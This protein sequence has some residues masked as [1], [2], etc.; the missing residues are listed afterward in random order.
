MKILL[1]TGIYPPEIGGPATFVP[2]LAEAAVAAGHEVRVLTYGD[3]GT[4]QGPTWPVTVVPRSGAAVLRYLRYALACFGLARS[5]D[6]VFAQGAVSE[7]F[8]SAIAAWIARKPLVLRVPG[9]YAWEVAM[10][11]PGAELLDDFLKTRHGGTI[12][13]VER[14]ERWVA[15][16]AVRIVAPSRYL[17]SVAER[18]GAPSDRIRTVYAGIEPLP[19]PSAGREALRGKFGVDGKTVV[20][21][22]MRAVPWK[23]GDLLIRAFAAAPTDRLLAF[24]G[25]GPALAE[26]KALASSL[27]LADRVR[28]LGRVDRK[29]VAEWYL[30]AD[31]MALPS[32]YEGFPHV[33]YE[34]VSSGLPCLVSDRAGNPET[35]A[36]FP[37]YVEVLP[38]D[39]AASWTEAFARPWPR[40][41]A[42]APPVFAEKAKEILEILSTCAS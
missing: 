10:R 14:M 26:W 7:G 22:V 1:A 13:I 16:R 25:D 4:P 29:T 12:G 37:E 42:A 17:A 5:V 23:N 41:P 38:I 21:A 2:A 11:T 18:W 28:F 8:P 6:V 33:V 3:V 32:S 9:D 36:L 19:A 39:D 34:A 30:A 31:V 24:A 15:R 35:K 20:L 40:R 27:G